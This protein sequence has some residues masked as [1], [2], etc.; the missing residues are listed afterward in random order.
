MVGVWMVS[1][2]GSSKPHWYDGSPCHRAQSGS[3]CVRMI[4]VVELT[5]FG[6]PYGTLCTFCERK[7]DRGRSTAA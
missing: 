7:F 6:K 5:K 4:V 1:E 3:I 2:T